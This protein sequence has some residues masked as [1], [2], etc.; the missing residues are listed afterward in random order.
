MFFKILPVD[1]CLEGVRLKIRLIVDYLALMQER[2][3]NQARWLQLSMIVRHIVEPVGRARA[4]WHHRAND[5]V[6]LVFSLGLLLDVKNIVVEIEDLKLV[7]L[8]NIV[9]PEQVVADLDAVV[10]VEE[11]TVYKLI[12]FRLQSTNYLGVCHLTCP[13]LRVLFDIIDFYLQT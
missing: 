7:E 6:C 10:G 13:E 3:D 11:V 1:R 4:Q 8:S 9:P 12:D 2:R 5:L